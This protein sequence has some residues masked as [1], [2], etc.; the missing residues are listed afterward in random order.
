MIFAKALTSER[1]SAAAT[2]MA[3]RNSAIGKAI[4]AEPTTIEAIGSETVT[5]V[6]R[7]FRT[8]ASSSPW[9]TAF[10]ANAEPSV[11]IS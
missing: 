9:V 6:T 7:A 3:A 8:F 10:C 5:A 11:A 4:V 2:S 1:M